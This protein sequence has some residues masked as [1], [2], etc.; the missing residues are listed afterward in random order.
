[1][2]EYEFA[3][4]LKKSTTGAK[5]QAIDQATMMVGIIERTSPLIISAFDGEGM[6]SEE[7]KEVVITRTFAKYIEE[8]KRKG[9]QV[10]IA[11]IGSL[12]RIAVIDLI[13]G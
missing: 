9:T 7:E 6:Y 4:A 12:D 5:E 8:E 13:G 2:W 1:M 10:L 11:P 3:K